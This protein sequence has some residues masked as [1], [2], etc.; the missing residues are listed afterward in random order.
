MFGIVAIFQ[1]F[2]TC[3]HNVVDGPGFPPPSLMLFGGYQECRTRKVF[4]IVDIFLGFRICAYNLVDGLVDLGANINMLLASRYMRK[5]LIKIK[6]AR[7]RNR[8]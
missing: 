5:I 4:D 3:S 6:L 1:V 8:T 7:W 2:R